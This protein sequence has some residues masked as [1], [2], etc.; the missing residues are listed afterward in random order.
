MMM[1]VGISRIAMG[2]NNVLNR[3]LLLTHVTHSRPAVAD[4]TIEDDRL[5]EISRGGDVL[6]E[7]VASD[8]IDEFGFS[9]AA[10]KA[11]KTAPG[12]NAAR[13][14][15]CVSIQARRSRS[16]STLPAAGAFSSGSRLLVIREAASM[17]IEPAAVEPL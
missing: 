16:G 10:R 13:G 4:V 5:I 9:D 17:K 8:H 7:W 11:I 2:S 12:T 6:W 3:T 1:R 14:S 15:L